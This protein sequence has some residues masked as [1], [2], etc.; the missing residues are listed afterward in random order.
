MERTVDELYDW[1]HELHSEIETAQLVTR[2]AGKEVKAAKLDKLKLESIASKRLNMLR[3]L[4]FRFNKAKD[5]FAN[6]SI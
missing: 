4:K 3:D 2:A 6:E 1:I 5:Q